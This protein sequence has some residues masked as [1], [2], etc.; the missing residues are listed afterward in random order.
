M[1]GH[2]A[3]NVPESGSVDYS[4]QSTSIDDTTIDELI[5]KIVF[6][7]NR[8]ELVATTRAL[9][10]VLLAHHYVIPLFYSKT[11]NIAYWKQ[12]ARP[13]ELPQ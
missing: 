1:S 9:D 5:K 4:D 11:I 2:F 6:A 7:P 3:S 10:R 13:Q 12:L 8:D